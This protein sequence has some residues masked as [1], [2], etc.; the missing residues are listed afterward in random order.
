VREQAPPLV[1]LE[2]AIF[3]RGVGMPVYIDPQAPL[4][5]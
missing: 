4:P 1:V 3:D 5:G 2:I